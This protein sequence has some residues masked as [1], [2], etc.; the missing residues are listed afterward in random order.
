MNE[1]APRFAPEETTSAETRGFDETC[2]AAGLTSDEAA[3]VLARPDR[4]EFAAKMTASSVRMLRGLLIPDWWRH[5]L[6]KTKGGLFR[7]ADENREKLRPFVDAGIVIPGTIQGGDFVQLCE[8]G[9]VARKNVLR[10]AEVAGADVARSLLSSDTAERVDFDGPDGESL[11][12]VLA[13]SPRMLTKAKNLDAI[14][15]KEDPVAWLR[16]RRAILDPLRRVWVNVDAW[17]HDNAILEGND[18]FLKALGGGP[19]SDGIK[20][21]AL[22]EYGHWE[23]GKSAWAS[24]DELRTRLDFWAANVHG[25]VFLVEP[26]FEVRQLL[27][28]D[29]RYLEAMRDMLTDEQWEAATSEPEAAAHFKKFEFPA[30]ASSRISAEEFTTFAERTELPV[31][32][33]PGEERRAEELRD[34]LTTS[35]L[36]PMMRAVSPT[37]RATGVAGGS[38]SNGSYDLSTGEIKAAADNE[39]RRSLPGILFHETGHG[40]Q[41]LLATSEAGKGLN[42][43]F[44]VASALEPQTHSSYAE[45]FRVRDKGNMDGFVSESF[46]EDF[47]LFFFAPERLPPMKRETIS[48]VVA[49]RFPLVDAEDVRRRVRSVLGNFYGVSATDEIRSTSCENARLTARRTDRIDS[50]DARDATA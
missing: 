40:V 41:N 45:S 18:L 3:V 20:A 30:R 5:A 29:L 27:T 23:F 28:G 37:L 33:D 2:R 47:R 16:E 31:E 10:A 4:D 6:E 32:S 50:E 42:A 36:E 24:V 44:A 48:R 26:S 13:M 22:V 38:V 21:V 19:W 35:G 49:S 43:R 39:H 15:S 8:T 11:R 17:R 46:A 25:S 12:A 1:L 9:D 7:L 14:L 34:I